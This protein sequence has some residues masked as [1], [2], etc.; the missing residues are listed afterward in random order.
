MST[1]VE[2]QMEKNMNN[3]TETGFMHGFLRINLNDFEIISG[4]P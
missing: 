4:T 3:I 2:N 1:K